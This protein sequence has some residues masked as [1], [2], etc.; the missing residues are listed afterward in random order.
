[1]TTVDV[2][3]MT[4]D[5]T[6]DLNFN[7]FLLDATSG[8][9]S[10]TIPLFTSDGQQIQIKRVDSVILN[11]VTISPTSPQ[12]INSTLDSILISSLGSNNMVSYNTSWYSIN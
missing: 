10:I 5:G 3:Y 9:L 4:S 11:T 1:M 12:K 2:I 6:L 8:S 7:V